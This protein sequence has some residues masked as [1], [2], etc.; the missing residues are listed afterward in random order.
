MAG[1]TDTSGTNP[2]ALLDATIA[3]AI[4]DVSQSDSLDDGSTQDEAQDATGTNPAELNAAPSSPATDGDTGPTAQSAVAA[5]DTPV[6]D[7][8]LAGSEPVTITVDGETRT[9]EGFTRIPGQGIIIDEEKVPVFHLMA[10]RAESLDRQNRD[11][12]QRTQEYER[13]SEWK[14]KGPDGNERTLTGRDGLEARDVELAK[15]KAWS[16]VIEESLMNPALFASLVTVNEQGQIVPNVEQLRYLATRAQLASRDAA[17]EARSRF[18]STYQATTHAQQQAQLSEQ[19]PTLLWQTAEQVWGKEFPQ[20][21]AEDKTFLSSQ[22]QR[23]M[24]P[25][26]PAEVQSGQFKSGESVLDPS[27]Y[28]VMQDRGALR[29]Q[30]TATAT[31]TTT[32]NKFNQGQQQGRKPNGQ[33][34]PVPPSSASSTHPSTTPIKRGQEVWDDVLQDAMREVSV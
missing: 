1:T 20:L 30:M 33:R 4:A 23:Y 10:S 14:T 15:T 27:F 19:A 3:E 12:Y 22:V 25:A 24:R 5:H 6:D 28:A 32:A 9:V 21:T 11:L 16:Q 13:L 2:D 18:S 7:D 31:A 8:P 34:P 17:D 26:S 29:A